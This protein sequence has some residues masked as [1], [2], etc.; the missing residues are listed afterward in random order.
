MKNSSFLGLLQ[1]TDIPMNNPLSPYL[2]KGGLTL[3]KC[4]QCLF[5]GIAD[6][7]SMLF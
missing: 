5:M 1:S 6:R 2:T 4:P 3:K 7:V